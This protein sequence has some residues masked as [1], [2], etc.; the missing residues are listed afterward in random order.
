MSKILS[1]MQKYLILSLISSMILIACTNHSEYQ[2]VLDSAEHLMFSH[3]DSSLKILE[4]TKRTSNMSPD[5][6]ARLALL[7]TQAQARTGMTSPNDSL[8]NIAISHY[9]NSSDRRR[10][11]WSY[12]YA[13]DIYD[14]LGIDSL[15]VKYIRLSDEVADE[16]C[17]TT[18]LYY[19]NYFRGNMLNRN[20]PYEPAL[21]Y[22]GDA[23][24]Y[25][26][27]MKSDSRAIICLNEIGTVHLA[28]GDTEKAKTMFFKALA[29]INHD[30]LLC[31]EA[32]V[33]HKIALAYF[34]EE[35]DRQALNYINNSVRT[36]RA[37][38]SYVKASS[39][40]TKKCTIIKALGENDSA[41][42]YIQSMMGDGS[43][44]SRCI[45]EFDLSHIEENRGDYKNALLHLKAYRQYAD[46][47]H[48][49]E[50]ADKIVELE[51]E[52]DLLGAE[53]AMA[54]S[55]L[56]RR[57]TELIL[58]CVIF[59]SLIIILVIVW[60]YG[61]KRAQ[62][63]ETER[64]RESMI[65]TA[66]NRVQAEASR[67]LIEER[68][69][70]DA[71]R[72]HVLDTD[73]L[74]KRIRNIRKMPDGKRIKS[75]AELK[76]RP[77]EIMHLT[78]VIDVCHNGFITKLKETYPSLTDKDIELCCLIR[79]GVP[80]PDILHLLDISDDALRK[81]RQRL[82]ERLNFKTDDNLNEWLSIVDFQ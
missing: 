30:S 26:I 80:G 37:M 68:A 45:A 39:I 51:K 79:L 69:G 58:A 40:Y 27:A 44:V 43:L 41:E 32:P 3:P 61:R 20:I 13:S 16:V 23:L 50:I 24:N 28:L 46:T 35:D 67:I 55:E 66:V 74:I 25:A 73:M 62:L 72:Q 14:R 59:C 78:S 18:L 15:A 1:T 21:K 70:N 52:Y 76:L 48:K 2:K 5:D 82:K 53:A 10:L 12:L 81:R 71:F 29:L 60:A 63:L 8:I 17:D 77:N 9:E 47:L 75:K 4:S 11:A 57:N 64:A 19:V 54:R 34:A 49:M 7:L 6:L 31:Y 22:L 33:N 38:K 56:E 65:S 36:I 42:A